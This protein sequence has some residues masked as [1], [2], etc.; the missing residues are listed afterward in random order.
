M[1]IYIFELISA[2]H[3]NSSERTTLS[4]FLLFFPFTPFVPFHCGDVSSAVLIE[5]KAFSLSRLRLSS[6]NLLMAAG[7]PASSPGSV[8]A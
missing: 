7:D 1:F 6:P 5:D 3:S 2:I 8:T 4:S